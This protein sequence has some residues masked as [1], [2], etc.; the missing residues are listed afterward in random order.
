MKWELPPEIKVYE[1]L[2]AIADGRVEILGDTAK[3]YSSSRNKFYDVRYDRRT[4]A[5]M[6]NDNASFYKSYLGY[7]AIAYLMLSGEIVYSLGAAVSLKDIAWKDIN[8]KF[9]NDF[10]KTLEYIVFNKSSEERES[11]RIEVANILTQIKNLDLSM[12]GA[13]GKPPE[14]Y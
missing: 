12:L 3:V 14:G 5:I 10:G 2:G 9:K 13:K 8:Q 4:S 11:L 6:S 1:A 7:P